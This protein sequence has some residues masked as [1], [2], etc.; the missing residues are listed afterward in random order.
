ME[1]GNTSAL[2]MNQWIIWA[3]AVASQPQP[4]LPQHPPGSPT[5]QCPLPPPEAKSYHGA[6]SAQNLVKSESRGPTAPTSLI[7][8]T[9]PPSSLPS[10]LPSHHPVRPR[11]IPNTHLPVHL[12]RPPPG[13]LFPI[14]TQLLSPRSL[15]KCHLKVT[16]PDLCS[17]GLPFPR[18]SQ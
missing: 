18:L 17:K 8:T 1:V 14:P 16:L 4:L 12:Q 15:I 10:P 9:P 7:C 3:K 13:M 6:S 5:S 2:V 11:H